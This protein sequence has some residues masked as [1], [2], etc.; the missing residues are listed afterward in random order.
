[1]RPK[2]TPAERIAELARTFPS[3]AGAPGVKPWE[4]ETLDSWAATV[5]SSGERHAAR[6]I[7]AVWDPGYVWDCGR[8]DLMEALAA[9]DE[10]HRRALLAWAAEPWWP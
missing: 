5:A 10:A 6:F 8:F 7:L 9:W 2:W 3:L 4:P 1:M